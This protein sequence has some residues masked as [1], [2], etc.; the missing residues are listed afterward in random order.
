MTISRMRRSE[1]TT[2]T[3]INRKEVENMKRTKNMVYKP[4]ENADTVTHYM[5]YIAE[6]F[7]E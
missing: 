3:I 4:T 7:N 2:T 6:L 5:E 1:W